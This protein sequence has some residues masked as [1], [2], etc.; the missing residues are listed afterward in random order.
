[1]NLSADGKE[2]YII[3]QQDKSTKAH[4][5]DYLNSR[6]EP[7][8]HIGQPIESYGFLDREKIYP[9]R[10]VKGEKT[11]ILTGAFRQ[12]S[13]ENLV[14]FSDKYFE[15]VLGRLGRNIIGSPELRLRRVKQKKE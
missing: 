9:T 12:G 13:E 8:L 14:V 7:Y 4:P 1:M 11:D 6:K 3:Y 2:I 5:L 10:T 15:K